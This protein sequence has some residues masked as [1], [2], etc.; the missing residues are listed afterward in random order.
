[1]KSN[2]LITLIEALHGAGFDLVSITPDTKSELY[3]AEGA[4]KAQDVLRLRETIT[5]RITPAV[6]AD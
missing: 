4:H 3:V 2:G 1:M 6:S 5:V